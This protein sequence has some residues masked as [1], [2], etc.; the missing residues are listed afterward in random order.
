MD[1]AVPST[2]TDFAI[3]SQEGFCVEKDLVTPDFLTEW[4]LLDA[5]SLIQINS[6]ATATPPIF[7]TNGRCELPSRIIFLTPLPGFVTTNREALPLLLETPCIPRITSPL[8]SS[9]IPSTL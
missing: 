9:E 5:L 3:P 7:T 4:I 1:V 2:E 6:L 8:E